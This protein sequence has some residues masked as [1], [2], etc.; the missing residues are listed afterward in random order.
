MP[1]TVA[2]RPAM[3]R[4]TALIARDVPSDRPSAVAKNR[5][6]EAL[7]ICAPSKTAKTAASSASKVSSCRNQP[8]ITASQGVPRSG[9]TVSMPAASSGSV[10]PLPP[11]TITRR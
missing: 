6:W 11:S 9:G 8:A 7:Y 5:D 2:A 3:S 10:I 4:T 1:T